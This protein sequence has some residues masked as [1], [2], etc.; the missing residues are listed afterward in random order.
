MNSGTMI[1]NSLA[2]YQVNPDWPQYFTLP[3]LGLVQSTYAND[4]A[5]PWS[6]VFT[7][8]LVRNHVIHACNTHF[9]SATRFHPSYYPYL[10]LPVLPLSPSPF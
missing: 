8:N 3:N 7:Y 2:T 5:H 1:V 9:A 4:I 10:L 6:L